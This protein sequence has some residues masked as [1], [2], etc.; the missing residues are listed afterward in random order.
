VTVAVSG[1]GTSAVVEVQG[2]AGEPDDG[3]AAIARALLAPHGGRVED[4]VVPGRGRALRLLLPLAPLAQE[5]AP[6][7]ASLAA[8]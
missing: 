2:G 3:A 7:A 8:P 5:R 6:E 1:R 4:E